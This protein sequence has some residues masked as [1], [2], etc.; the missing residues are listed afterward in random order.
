MNTSATTAQEAFDTP[1]PAEP[2]PA[3]A[4]TASQP[5]A[6]RAT[7][8][9]PS[10]AANLAS[11]VVVPPAAATAQ[12][13]GAESPASAAPV[14]AKAKPKRAAAPPAAAKGTKAVARAQTP[15]AAKGAQSAKTAQAA[16]AAKA[17]KAAKSPDHVLSANPE[18]TTRPASAVTSAAADKPRKAK[19]KLVRDSFTM[20]QADFDLIAT[21]KQ[22]ALVFQ[23]PAKKSELLRAGLH[24]LLALGD[25]E[26]RAALDD[27][28]P[29][30]PGR[31]KK[32][33]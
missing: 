24:A 28:T 6:G 4:P 20:P 18:L 25:L 16:K 1:P 15:K 13:T 9:R 8:K 29:L 23:R 31:P 32:V 10:K 2:A 12:P 19:A 22:R 3:P 11:P 27:L 17:T 26:L 14:R 30:K 7:R 21:L 5:R 33:D